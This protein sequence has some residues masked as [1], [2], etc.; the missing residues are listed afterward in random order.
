MSTSGS[1][2]TAAVQ[3]ELQEE[4]QRLKETIVIKDKTIEELKDQ[5]EALKK[6]VDLY[7][8]AGQLS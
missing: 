6:Q 8:M 1:S 5:I 3:K 4:N 7:K 2:L